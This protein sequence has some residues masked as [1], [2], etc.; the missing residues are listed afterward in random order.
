MNLT[1]FYMVVD[2]MVAHIYMLGMQVVD[3]VVCNFYC[4]LISSYI[5]V[6]AL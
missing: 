2:S 1:G 5:V 3:W 4:S 6:G